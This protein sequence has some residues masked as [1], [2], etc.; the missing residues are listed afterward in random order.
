MIDYLKQNHLSLL[1]VGYLV[2]MTMLGGGDAVG[3][4][5][6]ITSIT[7][8]WVFN[9]AGQAIDYR[10]EGDTDANL[11]FTDA[12]TDR[13]GISTS[14]PYGL[15]DVDGEA[16]VDDLVYGSGSLATT[17]NAAGT[18]TAAQV[19]DNSLIVVSLEI[20]SVTLTF[21]T[22][23]QLFADCL[24]HVGNTTDLIMRN[25]STT[26]TA[27]ITIAD[28][29]NCVHTEGEGLTTVIDVTEWAHIKMMNID[30]TNCMLDVEIRQ[31]GD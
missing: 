30:D 26:G 14:S 17:S 19:C 13:V 12:S 10:F 22:A 2:L 27:I 1:I 24:P 20:G 31:D 21:P 6:A 23:A 25:A 3:S 18:F 11:L 7:N 16:Y 8:P 15:L 29:A 28:G 9:Q 5:T 4:H